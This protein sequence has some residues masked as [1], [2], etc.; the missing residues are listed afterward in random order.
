MGLTNENVGPKIS[1]KIKIYVLTRAELLFKV[2]Y[3]IPCIYGKF[4][5]LL[6]YKNC[7]SDKPFISEIMSDTPGVPIAMFS[8]S[9]DELPKLRIKINK[10]KKPGLSS[11]LQIRR[12]HSLASSDSP[13]D[14][15]G[16]LPKDV[17]GGLSTEPTLAKVSHKL[18][19]NGNSR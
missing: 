6:F 18:A 9:K 19:T 10:P 17:N 15:F 1:A 13:I 12:R 2:C 14:L 3:E 8:I 5:C 7:L 16:L 4:C 11:F